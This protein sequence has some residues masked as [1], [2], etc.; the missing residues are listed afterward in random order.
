V[1]TTKDKLIEARELI[2]QAPAWRKGRM[3]DGKGFCAVGALAQVSGENLHADA[4]FALAR[5]LPPRFLSVT[6]YND[7][8]SVR[9]H[10]I[11]RLYDKAIEACD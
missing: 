1:T 6:E 2:R 11:M 8:Y 7:H 5:A 9:H 10:E 4:Y 3:S